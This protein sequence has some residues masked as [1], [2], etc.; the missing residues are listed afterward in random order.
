MVKRVKTPEAPEVAKYYTCCHPY[1]NNADFEEPT[2]YITFARW[3]SNILRSTDYLHAIYYKP[4]A[5]GKVIFAVDKTYQRPERLLGEHRWNE[6]LKKPQRDEVELKSQIFYCTYSTDREVQ[7]YGWKDIS[8]DGY[9]FTNFGIDKW[10]TKVPYPA[11]HWCRS[12][13]ENPTEKP[14]CRPLP[15]AQ[16]PR[17]QPSAP[18]Q[19]PVVGS[20]DW[21][22][23]RDKNNENGPGNSVSQPKPAG[24]TKKTATQRANTAPNQ[25]SFPPLSAAPPGKKAQSPSPSPATNNGSVWG[26]RPSSVTSARPSPLSAPPTSTAH[27]T[28]TVKR[29][30]PR[31]G[32]APPSTPSSAERASAPTPQPKSAAATAAKDVNDKGESLDRTRAKDNKTPARNPS[33]AGQSWRSRDSSS[34]SGRSGGSTTASAASSAPSSPA[35]S[36]SA[37]DQELD[38]DA[39]A[40]DYEGDY[41]EEITQETY[42]ESWETT[43]AFEPSEPPAP[44]VRIGNSH[45]KGK[46]REYTHPFVEAVEQEIAGPTEQTNLWANLEPV[47]RSTGSVTAVVAKA[48]EENILLCPVHGG[49]CKKGICEA[50]KELLRAQKKQAKAADRKVKKEEGRKKQ[51]D[52]DD[53]VTKDGD[54]KDDGDAKDI[55]KAKKEKE[56]R[57]K[58]E[59]NG[60]VT[61][62][63]RK[64]DE[65]D[66]K[67]KGKGK[68]KDGEKEKEKEKDDADENPIE[69]ADNKQVKPD[70]N[71]SS[72]AKGQAKSGWDE[73]GSSDEEGYYDNVPS[74]SA[75]PSGKKFYD[76]DEYFD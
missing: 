33:R 61:K 16:V 4:K 11:P 59:G 47:I 43:S 75:R 41:D 39:S 15:S 24:A 22:Q 18:P 53:W 57:T 63:E 44:A 49:K 34:S 62:D 10:F 30:K 6:F 54:M 73:Y 19:R 20:S 55:G 60:W 70:I 3:I 1:P 8:V 26:N 2:D 13:V 71:Q 31:A 65:G 5:R 58:K 40:Y 66:T 45:A 17:P 67:G 56:R 23:M 64:G 12:P 68:E 25:S 9:F 52:G 76:D 74:F 69:V 46:G 14:L 51:K 50:Y 21:S 29:A 38:L 36:S 48:K 32:K 37:R 7:K 35:P 28:W 42:H 27:T 72:K